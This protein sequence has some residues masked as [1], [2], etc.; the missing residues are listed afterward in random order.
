MGLPYWEPFSPEKDSIWG[1][2][3]ALE[4]VHA[5]PQRWLQ[6]ELAKKEKVLFQ[7]S[8]LR[9]LWNFFSLLFHQKWPKKFKTV[10]A[11]KPNL[12]PS[13]TLF[14]TWAHRVD[15]V[16]LMLRWTHLLSCLLERKE[17]M[18]CTDLTIGNSSHH[19]F[20]GLKLLSLKVPP[21]CGLYRLLLEKA[22]RAYVQTCF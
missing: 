21:H 16:A 2:L 11:L 13:S 17:S 22:R 20:L 19:P 7:L 6:E 5:K 18:F 12:C 3:I 8:T 4:K 9:Y 1:N 15:L 10:K 14:S